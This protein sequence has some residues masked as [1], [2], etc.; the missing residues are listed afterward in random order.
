M[1][2]KLPFHISQVLMKTSMKVKYMAHIVKLAFNSILLW[3]PNQIK[4]YLMPTHDLSFQLHLL[5]LYLLMR[6]PI[7]MEITSTW[8]G[9]RAP[10]LMILIAYPLLMEGVMNKVYS[11]YARAM[12]LQKGVAQ[13]APTTRKNK[14]G[15]LWQL[16]EIVCENPF[17]TIVVYTF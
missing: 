13:D 12:R 8:N 11:I 4:Y 14:V 1:K 3:P 7:I 15:H 9:Q 2:R 17:M 16:S 6:A 5:L 10:V